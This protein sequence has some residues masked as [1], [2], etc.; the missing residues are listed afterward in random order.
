MVLAVF[1]GTLNPHAL[2]IYSVA[3]VLL[4]SAMAYFSWSDRAEGG[5][6]LPEAFGFE[7]TG[8]DGNADTQPDVCFPPTTCPAVTVE[9][10]DS[11]PCATREADDEFLRGRFYASKNE[12][13]PAVVHFNKS[14]QLDPKSA[15]AYIARGE[16]HLAR[17]DRRKAMQDFSQAVELSP[18]L[19][20][21]HRA[22]GHGH[23]A[24]QEWKRAI[25]ELTKAIQLNRRDYAAYA[26]RAYAYLRTGDQANAFADHD[27]ALQLIEQEYVEL[28]RV[29]Q[30]YLLK[31]RLPDGGPID[32][33]L[34]KGD[35]SR[36]PPHFVPAEIDE[37]MLLDAWQRRK[38]LP[39]YNE[40]R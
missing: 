27:K 38:Y 4:A 28:V 40:H 36:F 24:N 39:G 8:Q 20:A 6:I 37:G 2:P 1:I 15:K 11:S 14:I 16:L 10:K 30:P 9:A 19:A 21:A 7:A 35:R 29:V 13:D 26:A 32:G 22:L 25:E 17:G 34:F 33:G 18:T 31:R 5:V 12:L 3:G 23:L